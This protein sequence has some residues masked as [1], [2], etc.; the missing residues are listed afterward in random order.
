MKTKYHPALLLIAVFTLLAP[1]TALAQ[2]TLLTNLPSNNGG[3][4]K[5]DNVERRAVTFSTLESELEVSS[6]KLSLQNYISLTDVAKLSL[7][8]D[9]T[10]QPGDQ[11]GS[12]FIAPAS[13]SDN[14][15]EFT[16]TSTGITLAANSTYWL[17]IQ[18]GSSQEFRWHRSDPT[19]TP[20]ETDYASFGDQWITYNSG[21][22][23]Q[24]GT[25]GAHSFEII[26]TAIPEPNAIWLLSLLILGATLL[27]RRQ[28]RRTLS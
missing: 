18:S 16:F 1:T 26:G 6:V 12:D 9:G 23:W 25:N 5:V 11:I 2:H 17:V 3:G 14:T 28:K 27:H 24:I 21:V 15:A 22:D 7:H 13:S 4:G 8:L 10:N 20:L 19:V